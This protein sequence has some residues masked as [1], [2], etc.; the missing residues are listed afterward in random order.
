MKKLILLMLLVVYGYSAQLVLGV[1]PQQ[2]PLKLAKKWLKVTKYLEEQTGIKVVFKTETSIPKFEKMLYAGKYDI[3]YM[4]PYHFIVAKKTQN[5]EAFT[6]ADKNIVGIVLSKEKEVDFSKDNLAGKTFLFPAPN[7]FA[8]TLLPKFELR[9]K[10]GIDIDKEAKVLYVNSHDSV[11]KGISRGIGYLG[12][13]IV[14]T[15]NN[16]VDKNDKDKL[17]IVYKTDAY[18]SHPIAAHPR[19]KNDDIMKIQK[20]F[21][22]MPKEIKK[23]LSIKNFIVTNSAEYD[24]IKEVKKA[25]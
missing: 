7:A 13:G 24:V 9:E 17:N 8:A 16:F 23:S 15:F 6:R 11:Y 10:F 18:P 14:R 21:L 5:F 25:D 1:V 2:S 4:N 22:A 19:V 20:A 12:G 3:A